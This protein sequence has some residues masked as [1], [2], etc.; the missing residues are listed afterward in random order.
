VDD[1]QCDIRRVSI[2]EHSFSIIYYTSMDITCYKFDFEHE[3]KKQINES[4]VKVLFCIRSK[5]D[6]FGT[7]KS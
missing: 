7:S 5:S 4:K 2:K 3:V 6:I 1:C